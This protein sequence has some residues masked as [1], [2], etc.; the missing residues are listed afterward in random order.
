MSARVIYARAR[1]A[2][3]AMKPARRAGGVAANGKDENPWMPLDM[4]VL[5][6]CWAVHN[7]DPVL[8]ACRAALAGRLL[9]QGVMFADVG[10]RRLTDEAFFMH[11]QRHYVSVCR[12]LRDAVH[13]QGFAAYTVDKQDGVPRCVP[14]V[15]DALAARSVAIEAN[16]DSSRTK[17]SSALTASRR[18]CTRIFSMR[19]SISRLMRLMTCWR[20]VCRAFDR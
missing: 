10:F 5:A 16:L 12:D 7:N 14:R 15:M 3:A 4:G 9:G 18:C 6:D 11:V 20:A 17:P 13:V 2:A 8:R 19:G 1:Q